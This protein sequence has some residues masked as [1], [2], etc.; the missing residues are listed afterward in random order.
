MHTLDK[1]ISHRYATIL[2]AYAGMDHVCRLTF[3]QAY[4]LQWK[5]GE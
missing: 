5:E 3:L 1:C 2:S 4:A